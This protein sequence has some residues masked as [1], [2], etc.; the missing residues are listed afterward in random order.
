MSEIVEWLAGV[1]LALGAWLVA[2]P[3]VLPESVAMATG[4]AFWNYVLVGAG[5][6]VLS[7]YNWWAADDIEPGSVLAAAGSAVLGLWMLA[8]PYLTELRVDGWLL[9]NDLIVGA[10]VAVLGAYSAYEAME[11]EGETVHTTT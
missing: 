7:G 5:I 11:F 2:I 1:N 3:F 8:V 4:F 10:I 9:W 6:A